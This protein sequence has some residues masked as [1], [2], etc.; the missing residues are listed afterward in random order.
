MVHRQKVIGNYIVD[1]YIAAAKLVI[2]LD[3]SGHYEPQ[4]QQADKI[5]DQQLKEIGITILR[6]S[7]LDINRNFRGV[8]EDILRH[9]EY[10]T[11]K[12]FQI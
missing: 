4:G 7:N 3:G 11:R 5:R 2:E 8:C 1:F 6:Y 12:D 10:Q 9:I